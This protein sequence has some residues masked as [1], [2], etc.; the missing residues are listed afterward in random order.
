MGGW[1]LRLKLALMGLGK[2]KAGKPITRFDCPRGIWAIF[3]AVAFI[4]GF[5]T[6]Y[7]CDGGKR[8]DLL[9][10]EIFVHGGVTG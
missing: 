4:V 2:L 10:D 1:G 7:E 8:A 5:A 6:A 3:F 9:L